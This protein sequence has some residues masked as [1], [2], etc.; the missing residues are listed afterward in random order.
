MNTTS[1]NSIGSTEHRTNSAPED[2][3]Q[4]LQDDASAALE[5]AREHG[6]AQFEQYRDSAAEQIKTL[7]QTAQSAAQQLQGND[8]L[9]LSHYVTDIAQS[10]ST[11]AD[12]LRNKSAE[13]LLQQASNLA[14]ENPAL[15][16]TGSVAL[17]FGLSR[18]LRASSPSPEAT[19][20]TMAA[21]APSDGM[22]H[23]YKTDLGSPITA[24]E[25]LPVTPPHLGDV[26]H[27]SRP[28]DRS[29]SPDPA[30]SGAFV[31]TDPLGGAA[32]YPDTRDDNAQASTSAD[33]LDQPGLPKNPLSRGDL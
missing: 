3:L 24:D 22:G 31:P 11:L 23:S 18:F 16:I 25:A 9:G 19:T 17:G 1:E 4:N 8:T 6:A 29:S 12:N 13:Q 32:T 20:S 30:G 5:S 7:A 2:H 28:A 15:F 26:Q 10:M 33:D 14:R 27:S 21:S